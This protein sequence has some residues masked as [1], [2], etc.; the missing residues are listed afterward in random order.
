MPLLSDEERFLRACNLH[1]L[2]IDTNFL[3]L[4]LIGRHGAD[5][6]RLCS[7]TS[8]YTVNDYLFIESMLATGAKLILT[9]HSLAEISNLTFDKLF[10]GE[11]LKRYFTHVVTAITN[12]DE[13]F[14]EKEVLLAEDNLLR[15]GFTDMANV[16]VAKGGCAVLTE[17][18]DLFKHLLSLDYPVMNL[19]IIRTISVR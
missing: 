14:V 13:R 10:H 19:D 16:I 9:P 11:G 5:K 1:G 12:A 3:I 17:D 15:F 7:R 18:D 6:I 4:L 2:L 8:K